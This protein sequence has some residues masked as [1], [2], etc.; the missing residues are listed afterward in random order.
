MVTPQFGGSDLF[1]K[2]DVERPY[3]EVGE[4]LTRVIAAGT[5]P[6]DA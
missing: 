6:V 5:N 1:E 4:V 3:P 2:R